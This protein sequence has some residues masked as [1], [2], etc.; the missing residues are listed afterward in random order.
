LIKSL[1]ICGPGKIFTAIFTL[2]ILILCHLGFT[3]FFR[4]SQ[5]A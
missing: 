4:S 5:R 3:P 2:N 1:F